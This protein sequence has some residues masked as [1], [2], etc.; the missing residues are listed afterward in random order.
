M[1][2][3]SAAKQESKY[4]QKATHHNKTNNVL[5]APSED[6]NEPRHEKT[7][8]LH[9]QKQQEIGCKQGLQYYPRNVQLFEYS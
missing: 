1:N 3:I 2:L 8:V 9:M 7:N 4:W 5:Y 6:I